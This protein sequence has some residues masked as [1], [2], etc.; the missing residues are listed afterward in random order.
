MPVGSSMRRLSEDVVIGTVDERR[1]VNAGQ[2]DVGIDMA[3]QRLARDRD[4]AVP[5]DVDIGVGADLG[6]GDDR[7]GV[8][9]DL[10]KVEA[11]AALQE[12]ADR[13]CAV[14]IGVVELVGADDAASVGEPDVV[15]SA[16]GGDDIIATARHNVVGA[17]SSDDGVVVGATVDLGSSDAG[18]REL[19]PADS[20]ISPV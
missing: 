17:H 18:N 9:G 7:I 8:A 4:G 12:A 15:G 2:K 11:V 6:D 5:G 19:L 3:R 1:Q 14:A 16:A 20:T 13:I 10:R